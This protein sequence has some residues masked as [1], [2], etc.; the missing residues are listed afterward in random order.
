MRAVMEGGRDGH[1]LIGRFSDAAA[2]YDRGL[3]ED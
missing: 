1:E 2:G 3:G